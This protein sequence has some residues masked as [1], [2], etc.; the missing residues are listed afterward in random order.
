LG[1]TTVTELHYTHGK[2]DGNAVKLNSMQYSAII[3][4]TQGVCGTEFIQG[5]ARGLVTFSIF[6][7]SPNGGDPVYGDVIYRGFVKTDGTYLTLKFPVFSP[8]DNFCDCKSAL[9]A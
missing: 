4:F 1:D 8:S 2:L 3:E 5:I 7:T 9:F 6:D